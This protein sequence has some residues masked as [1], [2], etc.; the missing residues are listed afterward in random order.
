MAHRNLGK[1]LKGDEGLIK[2]RGNGHS[3]NNR[4]THRNRIDRGEI[5]YATYNEIMRLFFQPEKKKRVN[6]EER[7]ASRRT[8][9]LQRSLQ[10]FLEDNGGVV[11]GMGLCIRVMNGT[12]VYEC[13]GLN[14]T[15]KR[16][17]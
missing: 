3:E 10:E 1:Y 17:D 14:K 5:Y 2:A 9:S 13:C 4:F 7:K 6:S 8:A 12:V 15:V 11:G 16:F